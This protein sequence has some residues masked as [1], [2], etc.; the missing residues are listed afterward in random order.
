MKFKLQLN[1][2]PFKVIKFL[3]TVWVVVKLLDG[4]F[5][6]FRGVWLIPG[7]NDSDIIYIGNIINSAALSL[8]EVVVV[9]VVVEIVAWVIVCCE[10]LV[11]VCHR[12]VI[13]VVVH[14]TV[15]WEVNWGVIIL[16][17]II[18]WV[19]NWIWINVILI[20]YLRVFNV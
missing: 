15:W 16:I 11:H 19:S 18:V 14:D 3:H 9:H 13:A 12:S 4:L 5:Y 1:Y 20:Y 6:L 2:S 17:T 10:V 7:T 8:I